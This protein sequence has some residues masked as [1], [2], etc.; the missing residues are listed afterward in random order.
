MLGTEPNRTMF[1]PNMKIEV[2]ICLSQ[3]PIGCAVLGQT[4]VWGICRGTR[5]DILVRDNSVAI[6]VFN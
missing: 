5:S 2:A 6:L 3:L 1:A 4:D